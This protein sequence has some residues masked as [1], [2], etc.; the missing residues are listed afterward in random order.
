MPK[1]DP[2]KECAVFGVLLIGE[3]GSGKSILINNLLGK[4]VAHEGHTC[5]SETDTI[6]QYRGTVAG[7]PVALY[8]T[9]GTDETAAT[10]RDIWREIKSL[11][12][13]K[14][15]CLVI[16]CPTQMCMCMLCLGRLAVYVRR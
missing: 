2:A 4:E 14:K 12:K 11:I 8:D 16:F 5:R 9:P 13:S 7:V 3:T 6:T 1:R 15:V 10:D